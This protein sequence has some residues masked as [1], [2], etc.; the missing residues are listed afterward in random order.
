MIPEYILILREP[1]IAK[2]LQSSRKTQSK[3][4]KKKKKN[5]DHSSLKGCGC[6][7]KLQPFKITGMKSQYSKITFSSA[8]DKNNNGNEKSKNTDWIKQ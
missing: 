6:G 3:K 8:E 2:I 5:E 1:K 7:M 4:K